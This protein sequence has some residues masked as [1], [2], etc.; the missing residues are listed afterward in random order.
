LQ[1]P[2][3][4]AVC[5]THRWFFAAGDIKLHAMGRKTAID[6]LPRYREV[7]V[8]NAVQALR[9]SL[10]SVHRFAA[11]QRAWLAATASEGGWRKVAIAAG[12]VPDHAV[13]R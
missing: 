10:P 13:T 2:V 4:S 11:D 6:G 3:S 9:D 7:L 8:A 5:D 1:L 12:A